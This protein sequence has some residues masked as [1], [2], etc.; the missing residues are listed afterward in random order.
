MDRETWLQWRRRGI[1]SSDAAAICGL[2]PWRSP[3]AVYLDKIGELP[4]EEPSEAME[5]GVRLEPIVAEAW[6]ERT[7]KKIRRRNAILQHPQYPWMLANV[8]RFVVGENAV[9]E[10][11]TTSAFGADA[12]ADGAVPDHYVIQVQHQMAVTGCEKAYLAVLIGGNH[13]ECREIERD[14]ELIARLIEIEAEFWRRVEERRP[15]EPDGSE[16]DAAAI[17][18]LY[19]E[20]VEG[21]TVIL[22][23][24]AREL[25]EAR[26]A[27][28]ADLEDAQAR[29]RAIDSRLQA[30]VGDAE[31]AYLPGSSKP[32]VTW[33]TVISQRVDT[34]ALK[35]AGL[36]EAYTKPS[37][38][39]RWL[40]KEDAINE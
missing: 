14:E 26:R 35:A 33:K 16:A 7:G 6:A 27:A 4:D 25:L 13:L 29:L 39:R 20:S 1:G 15:P 21:K 38:S 11:K 28:K 31:A 24:D 36:Y 37:V 12:W 5:W 3:L 17:R 40:V 18:R 32:V 8:D 10:V 30:L 9:L 19:P 2:S 23:P 34:E 22:P